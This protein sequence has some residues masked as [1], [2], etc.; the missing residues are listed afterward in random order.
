KGQLSARG[1]TIQIIDTAGRTVASTNYPGTPSLVQQYLRITELMYHPS[2]LAGNTNSPE[3]F[4]YVEQK[5]IGPVALNLNGVRFTNGI[6]FTFA[7]SAVT[8]LAPGQSV[9]VVKNALLFAARYG[10][11]LAI[12]G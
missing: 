7:G 10:G 3:E 9:L 5:N 1:E 12:A 6:S 2:A 4:E 8:N 11:S